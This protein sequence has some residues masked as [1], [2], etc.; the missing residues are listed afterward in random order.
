MSS[1]AID[2]GS[3]GVKSDAFEKRSEAM[4]RMVASTVANAK[5]ELSDGV[6]AAVRRRRDERDVFSLPPCSHEH[7][8]DRPVIRP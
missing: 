1:L 3:E 8:Y 5:E 6:A 7:G 4:S 2:S